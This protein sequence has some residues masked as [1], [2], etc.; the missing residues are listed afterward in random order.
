M[1]QEAE[2]LSS[3]YKTLSY[4]TLSSNPRTEKR[5]KWSPKELRPWVLGNSEAEVSVEY[6]WLSVT[7]S[8]YTVS[9][10]RSGKG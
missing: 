6:M 5:K 10:G 1:T 7:C 3:K 2:H 9:G 8:Q 4:K